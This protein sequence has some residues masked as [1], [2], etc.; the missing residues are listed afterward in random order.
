MDH[1]AYDAYAVLVE[2]DDKRV[3]YSGDFRGHGRKRKVFDVFLATPPSNIDVLLMEGSTLGRD[4]GETYPSEDQLENRFVRL[5]KHIE[6]M[7]LVWS[8]AQNIDRLVTIYKACRKSGRQFI[9]DMYT[10][11]IL[12][13]IDNP[14]LPQPGWSNLR[15]FLP[16]SQKQVIRSRKLFA[17]AKSFSSHRIYPEQLK[18]IAGSSV[19]LFRPSMVKDLEEAE[20]LQGAILMYSLWPGYFEEERLSWFKDWLASSGIQ[21][22]RCHTSGHASITDL[23]R[24][25]EALK[26]GVLVPVH[27]FKPE[28]YSDHF[29]HVVLRDDG[30]WWE[31]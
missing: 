21:M 27:T 14:N 13:A 20:C 16:R 29:A 19:M 25:A 5:F 23:K 6:G 28:E 12:R 1:S 31:V 15:V 10:A 7:A 3:F 11:S 26:P 2:A 9:I 22:E 17:F 30:A 4:A 18:G 8:A 24:L